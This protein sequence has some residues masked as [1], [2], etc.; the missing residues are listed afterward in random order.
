MIKQFK[1]KNRIIYLVAS[2]SKLVR[3]QD[4]ISPV[5]YQV[6]L[7]KGMDVDWVKTG[8]GMDTFNATIVQVKTSNTVYTHI[9]F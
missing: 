7:G 6:M 5:D 2:S 1:I 8:Q 4:A 3:Q 9:V